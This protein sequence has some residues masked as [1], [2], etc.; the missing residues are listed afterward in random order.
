MGFL[1]EIGGSFKIPMLFRDGLQITQ[2][3]AFGGDDTEEE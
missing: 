3:K 2:G 1:E